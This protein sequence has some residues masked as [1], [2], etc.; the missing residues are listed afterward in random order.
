MDAPIKVAQC[1]LSAVPSQSHDSCMKNARKAH[2][3]C[4]TLATLPL[5]TPPLIDRIAARSEL[6]RHVRA[7]RTLTHPAD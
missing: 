5:G 7:D 4:L 3:G 2:G 1:Y 6:A